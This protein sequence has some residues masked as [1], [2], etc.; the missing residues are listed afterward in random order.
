ML[1]AYK[2]SVSKCFILITEY[3]LIFNGGKQLLNM[4][5]VSYETCYGWTNFKSWNSVVWNN[6]HV[7]RS[8]ASGIGV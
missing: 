3:I 2:V 4:L 5:A 1:H 7:I 6:A 8:M